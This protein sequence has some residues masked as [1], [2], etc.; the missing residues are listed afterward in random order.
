MMARSLLWQ[1]PTLL[2]RVIWGICPWHNQFGP[3]HMNPNAI[4]NSLTPLHIASESNLHGHISFLQRCIP[5][6]TV[7][8]DEDLLLVDS[9]LP[10]DSFNIVAR[11]RLADSEAD[12]RIAVVVQHF[13]AANRPFAW[14]VGPASR[15]LDLETRLPRHGLRPAESELGMSMELRDLPRKMSQPEGLE[16][17][18]VSSPQ[19]VTDFAAVFA[20][21]W[22]PL[23]HAVPPFYSAATPI[24]LEP[25]CPMILFVGYFEGLPVSCSELFIDR[26]HGGLTG[27]YSIATR[28]EFRRR[29]IGSALAWAA[30]DEARRQD[31]STVVLQ[32]SDAGKGVY[33]RLGFKPCCHFTEY[34]LP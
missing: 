28:R 32:S 27:L 24:L 13:R 25:G 34:K 23:D 6:M 10:S 16:I 29:G 1:P 4:S 12:R 3:S 31:L 9:G 30:A 18:R 22:E 19:D 11:A 7:L 15:P 33:T 20:A 26:S 5:K 21:N 8:E 17:R 14:W 2:R